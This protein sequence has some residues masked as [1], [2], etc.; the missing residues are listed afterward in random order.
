MILARWILFIPIALLGSL[1]AGAIGSYIGEMAMGRFSL[2]LEY[3]PQS[4]SGFFSSFAFVIVG[5]KI[6]PIQDKRTK[7]ILVTLF[8]IIGLIS[9]IGSSFDLSNS[10]NITGLSIVILS[11]SLYRTE[12]EALNIWK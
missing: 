4:L 1:L 5:L 8:V 3:I 6:A 12:V 2:E 7:N 11:I 9:A 10:Y